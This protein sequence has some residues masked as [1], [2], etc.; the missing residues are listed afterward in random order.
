ME[1]FRYH[2]FI[3]DQKKPEGVPGCCARGSQKVIDALRREL[4]A[5]G[6]ND[7]VQVTTCGSLGLCES[8]PN[9]IVYPEGIW[10]SGLRA[11]DVPEI[12][13]SH[14]Q[15]GKP[16]SRLV[17]DN[18]E[19]LRAEIAMN[20]NRY[21]AS[22]KAKDSAGMLPDDVD[23][24]IR[25]FRESRAILTALELDIFTAIGNGGTAPQI[26][27]KIGADARATEML[28][29]V[30]VSME[31]LKKG[32]DMFVNTATSSRYFREGSPDNMRMA[33]MHT[34]HLWDTWSTLTE[35]VRQGTSI[36]RR[37][38]VAGEVA[39]NEFWTKAF[40][41]AMHRN[42]RERAPHLI[43]A[44]G[45]DGVKRMIDLGGGSG[46]YSI[47]FANAKPD[48][49]VDLL[50]IADVLPLTAE[51][52]RD[53]GVADRVTLIPGDLR[54]DK[55]AGGHD[56]ALLSAICH[57]FGVDENKDLL[58]RAY[59]AL[60][61]GGRLVIQEFILEPD[62]TAPRTA[63]L[64]ALNMLVGTDKGSAYSSEEY[65]DWLNAAGFT[66]VQHVKLPG[67]SALMIG[68]K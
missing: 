33:L 50:D 9:M 16:V 42:A 39:R 35:C 11:D 14:F 24:A 34:V 30:L 47:A 28:L 53:A 4:G 26:A 13:E 37:A 22:M 62:K 15:N 66:D 45:L 56:L 31:L 29:N 49:K 17:R 5:R 68:T 43:R 10:Y 23:Q 61:K 2:V 46:A 57:M 32:G 52:V 54:A 44:V 36:T 21:L 7:Q 51:Y 65:A 40:I 20:R 27:T 58:R 67:P 38:G 63:T 64:F 60:D 48:L 12:V 3:C 59:D 18:P 55:F 8:G 41:A 19:E 6:L 25:G 1:P